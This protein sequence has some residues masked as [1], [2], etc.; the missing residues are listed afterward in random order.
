LVSIDGYLEFKQEL[1]NVLAET[2]VKSNLSWPKPSSGELLCSAIRV[3]AC[4]LAAFS[5][6]GCVEAVADDASGSGFS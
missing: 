5:P 2:W 4:W 1:K 3:H 6:P